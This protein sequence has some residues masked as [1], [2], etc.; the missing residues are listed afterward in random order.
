[1]L[2][3]NAEKSYY[4]DEKNKQFENDIWNVREFGQSPNM[5]NSLFSINFSKIKT[6]WLKSGL[7][8]FVKFQ[9][10]KKMNL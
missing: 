3:K 7:K 9:D 2:L 1:M 5:A 8:H 6:E 4:L 10:I